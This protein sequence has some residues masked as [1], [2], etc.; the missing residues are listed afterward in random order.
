MKV[1]TATDADQGARNGDFTWTIEGELVRIGEP[2]ARDV[3]NPEGGCGCS[4]AFAGLSSLRATTTAVVRELDLSRA[5]VLT[6][7]HGSLVSAGYLDEVLD[8]EQRQGLDAEVDFLLEVAAACDTGAVLGRS[9]D[10]LF[11]RASAPVEH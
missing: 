1:L 4:R 7:L 2:C 10:E 11:V 5:D 8:A 3:Y 6:A 9:F